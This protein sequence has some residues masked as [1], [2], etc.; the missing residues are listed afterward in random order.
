MQS[1]RHKCHLLSTIENYR[2]WNDCWVFFKRESFLFV[3]LFLNLGCWSNKMCNLGMSPW[4][5]GRLLISYKTIEVGYLKGK[6]IH[7]N[8]KLIVS[9]LNNYCLQFM[10]L[11]V[12]SHFVR[13]YWTEPSPS[14]K[15]SF[16]TFGG[17]T[18]CQA[19]IRSTTTIKGCG[20]PSSDHVNLLRLTGDGQD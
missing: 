4:K 19:S 9:I 18:G 15:S 5:T 17:N 3:W 10:L 20:V 2:K 14:Q 11:F 7:W 6:T 16:I 1:L 12:Y 13:F 8:D